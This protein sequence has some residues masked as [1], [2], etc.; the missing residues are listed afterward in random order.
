MKLTSLCFCRWAHQAYSLF[1]HRRMEG[2]PHSCTP[3]RSSGDT[4]LGG[5]PLVWW[6]RPAGRALEQALI[7]K[8]GELSVSSQGHLA[9]K[10]Q[11]LVLPSETQSQSV[12]DFSWISVQMGLALWGQRHP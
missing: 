5:A 11:S 10:Q 8:S 12:S 1:I 3:V 7:R 6:G 9:R 2:L 4:V